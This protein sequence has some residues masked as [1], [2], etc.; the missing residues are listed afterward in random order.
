VFCTSQTRIFAASMTMETID[1][2]SSAGHNRRGNVQRLQPSAN[3]RKQGSGHLSPRRARNLRRVRR[4]SQRHHANQRES[5]THR[6]V[7]KKLLNVKGSG[8]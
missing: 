3:D 2:P 4:I 1:S 6:R 5:A 7:L 8:L